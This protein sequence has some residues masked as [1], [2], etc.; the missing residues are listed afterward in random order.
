LS[1]PERGARVLYAFDLLELNGADLRREPIGV[2]KATPANILRKSQRSL[3]L[4]GRMEHP[5]GAIVFQH[6]CKMPL[7]GMSRSGGESSAPTPPIR[8]AVI[9]RPPADGASGVAIVAPD[10]PAGNSTGAAI[11]DCLRLID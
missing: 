2:R 4:N 3:R 10:D 1:A 6:A 8:S 11:S 9:D 5:E 7:E